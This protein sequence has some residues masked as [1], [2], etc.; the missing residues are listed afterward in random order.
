MRKNRIARRLV[1]LTAAAILSV[2][3]ASPVGL[4]QYEEVP[5]PGLPGVGGTAGGTTTTTTSAKLKQCIKKAKK[6]HR[7]DPVAKK[8]AIKKCK[9]K[10]GS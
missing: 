10:F 2:G 5:N 1:G 7:D 9:L 3:V 4:A 8:K 6:K